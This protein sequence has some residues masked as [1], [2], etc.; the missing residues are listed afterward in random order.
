MKRREFTA[1]AGVAVLGL[2]GLAPRTTRAQAPKAGSDYVVLRPAL[3]GGTDGK[4]EVIEFFWYGCPHCNRFQPLIEPWAKKLPA[5]VLYRR[6][7]VA[8]REEFVVHQR[9]YY[10]LEALGQIE[11]V[12]KKVFHA[13]HVE[14]N[15]LNKPEAI[16]DFMA[17]QGIDRA[18][19]L[20]AFNS[21]GVQTKIR[22]AR[23][24]AE[25]YKI[26]GVPAIGVNGRYW[27]S[28]ALAGSLER[29]L[30]VADYLIGQARAGR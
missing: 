22:Q 3:P 27:T 17:R 23:Q 24:I 25:G 2:A 14:R 5:D 9:I 4:I 7:P 8:F 19:F 18:K 15:P 1:A 6:V 11:A 16:A 21:F 10:A 20:E 29:S 13:V 26:D 30:Q 28:G 12:H